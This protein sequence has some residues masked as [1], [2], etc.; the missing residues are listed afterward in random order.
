MNRYVLHRFGSN[1]TTPIR[2]QGCTS[3]DHPV[4]TRCLSALEVWKSISSK[5]SED[6]SNAIDVDRL[7]LPNFYQEKMISIFKKNGK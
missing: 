1:A 2:K 3:S 5:E 7:R 6:I 4:H